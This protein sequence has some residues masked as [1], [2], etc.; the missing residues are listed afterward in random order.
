MCSTCV[1]EAFSACLCVCVKVEV[2]KNVELSENTL[3]LCLALF[4]PH[5]PPA[6]SLS[7]ILAA[8]RIELDPLALSPGV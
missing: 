2:D 3:P 4:L 1:S 5:N 7:L 6:L 8:R